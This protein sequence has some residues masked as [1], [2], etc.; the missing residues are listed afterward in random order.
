MEKNETL[1]FQFEAFSRF[2][3]QWL[4]YGYMVST[5]IYFIEKKKTES[6]KHKSRIKDPSRIGK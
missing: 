4:Y 5:F 2:M 3:Y 6:F 1:L